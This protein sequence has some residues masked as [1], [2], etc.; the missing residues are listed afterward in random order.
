MMVQPIEQI[1]MNSTDNQTNIKDKL[2]QRECYWIK[3]LKCVYP[4][5]LNWTPGNLRS[6]SSR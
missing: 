1:L 5:G 2:N 6:S 4:Q 3:K